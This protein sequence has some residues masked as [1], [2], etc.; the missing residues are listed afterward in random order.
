MRAAISPQRVAELVPD[1]ASVMV[2]GFMG[3]GSPHRVIAAL[4]ALAAELEAGALLTIDLERT[5]VRLLPLRR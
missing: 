2:G 3:V 5:R 1:G 4:V